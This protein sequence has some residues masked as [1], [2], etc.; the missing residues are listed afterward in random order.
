VQDALAV[1]AWA[2][3]HGEPVSC[4]ELE[5][6]YM[7]KAEAQRKLDEAQRKDEAQ[8]KAE[9]QRKLGEAQDAGDSPAAARLVRPATGDDVYGMSVIERLSFGEPW[10]ESSILGDLMLEYSDYVVCENDGFILGYAGLHRIL[11]EGHITNIAVH[12]SMRKRG[13]GGAALA[14]LMRRAG[15]KGVGS[16]TLEVR[17]DDESAINF[18]E[19]HGFRA[20]GV[21]KD[22]YPAAGGREDALIMWRHMEG[23]V[24]A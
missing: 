18:Y 17:A 10:L 3:E 23:G 21:R 4:E 19:K 14:E 11:E 22:Y 12:P 5:P 8:L 9:A 13:V 24:T 15:E 6:I 20:E 7:R 2:L 1:L 16:F